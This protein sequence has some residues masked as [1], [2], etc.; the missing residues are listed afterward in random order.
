MM[1]DLLFTHPESEVHCIDPYEPDPTTPQVCA[2]T[3]DK[4]HQNVRLVAREGRI[5]LHEGISVE[6]LA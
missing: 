4:F 5:H 3:K 2:Q 6:V 1:L